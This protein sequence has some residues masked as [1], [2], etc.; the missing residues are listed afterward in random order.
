MKR[1]AITGGTGFV[2]ANLVRRLLADGHEVHLLVRSGYNS[3]RIKEIQNSVR[4]HEVRLDDPVALELVIKGIRPD[5][6]FHLAAYGAYSWQTDLRKII[7]TNIIGT[8]NLVEACLK[9]GF[10]TFVNTGSSSEYG[11]KNHAPLED[12]MLD[13]NSHYAV[14][15][16]AA[17][18]FC[19]YTAR[20]HSVKIT[21]LRLY[22]V[23]GPYEEPGRLIPSLVL[24][25]LK[26]RLPNL[27]DPNI[28]RDFIYVSD[29]CEAYILAAT[30]PL[31]VVGAVYNVGSGIQTTL[32]EVIEV[33]KREMAVKDEP[34]WGTMPDRV[35][36][37]EVWVADSRKIR[38]D[39]KWETR[40][41]FREGFL[42]MLNWLAE[43]PEMLKYYTH[44]AEPIS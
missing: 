35:W 43:N 19:R 17:A 12:E 23:Y 38:S 11:F 16:A 29:V 1:V 3:W 37:T 22:S 44:K 41:D 32:R 8:I 26:G 10:E 15:K 42:R 24:H 40:V 18:Q 30:S 20:R 5:W 9:T 14:A 27:V 4:L 7:E 39:L 36:D 2:G 34:L 33:V 6:V 21:T 13:P 25:G 28:A 31:Q